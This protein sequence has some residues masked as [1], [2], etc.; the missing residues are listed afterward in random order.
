MGAFDNTA[1]MATIRGYISRLF[2]GESCLGATIET[3][4]LQ[5]VGPGKQQQHRTQ[6]L[7]NYIYIYMY[8]YLT[9]IGLDL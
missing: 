2:F 3:W 7:I 6:G 5:N 1:T 8:V 4:V 9:A